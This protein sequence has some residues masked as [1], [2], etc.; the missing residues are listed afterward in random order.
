MQALWLSLSST[1]RFSL[2]VFDCRRFFW[3]FLLVAVDLVLQ[4][5]ACLL[6]S[7]LIY[8]LSGWK[9]LFGMALTVNLDS[10]FLLS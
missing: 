5:S 9:R 3:H 4:C 2:S 7:F 8:S 10:D 6:M 1:E